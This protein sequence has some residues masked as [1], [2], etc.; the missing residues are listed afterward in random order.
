MCFALHPDRA[1]DTVASASGSEV[2]MA[3]DRVPLTVEEAGAVLG[4]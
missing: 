2:A 4:I 3:S 1:Y